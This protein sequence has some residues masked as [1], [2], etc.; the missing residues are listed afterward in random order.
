[1]QSRFEINGTEALGDQPY[2]AGQL[3]YV[4]CIA[5]ASATEIPEKHRRIAL[6]VSRETEVSLLALRSCCH[7]KVRYFAL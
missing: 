4:D 3:L 2:L 7:F 1:M 6:F 5:G